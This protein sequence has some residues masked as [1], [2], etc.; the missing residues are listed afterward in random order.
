MPESM[1]IPASEIDGTGGVSASPTPASRGVWVGVLGGGLGLPGFGVVGLPGG[2][3]VG[4]G[5]PGDGGVPVG[6]KPGVGDGALGDGVG[7]FG[8]GAPGVGGAPVGPGGGA[9]CDASNTPD[10]PAPRRL[11]SS[12]ARGAPG[13]GG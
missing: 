7:G 4:A 13:C 8:A 2:G 12:A 10:A 9:G 1:R 5:A 3:G 6:G 11:G